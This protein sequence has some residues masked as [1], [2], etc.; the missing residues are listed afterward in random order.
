MKQCSSQTRNR[1]SRRILSNSLQE[2]PYSLRIR[3]RALDHG[4]SRALHFL[5]GY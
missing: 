5:D 1:A 2:Y 4:E 3:E